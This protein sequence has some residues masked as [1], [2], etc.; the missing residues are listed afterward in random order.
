LCAAERAAANGEEALQVFCETKALRHK[1]IVEVRK[2][3]AQLTSEIN[4]GHPDL[5]LCID[6]KLPPP[7]ETQVSYKI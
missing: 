4:L 7:T 2:L 3:R 6:P 1:G 5:N